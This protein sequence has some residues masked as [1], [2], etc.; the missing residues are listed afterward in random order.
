[1]GIRWPWRRRGRGE[2]TSV[3]LPYARAVKIGRARW[4]V[5]I[6]QRGVPG[7]DPITVDFWGTFDQ[8]MAYLQSEDEDFRAIKRRAA[9]AAQRA[10]TIKKTHRAGGHVG[11]IADCPRCAAVFGRKGREDGGGWT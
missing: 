1:M 9:E 6:G 11:A 7:C 2:L 5:E 10:W 3:E 8:M 4:R